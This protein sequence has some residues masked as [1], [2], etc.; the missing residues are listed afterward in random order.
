[1]IGVLAF[2]YSRYVTAAVLAIAW[3]FA[4]FWPGFPFDRGG[5]KRR[6]KDKDDR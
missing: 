3:A 6:S 1:M 5:R 4:L 2:L